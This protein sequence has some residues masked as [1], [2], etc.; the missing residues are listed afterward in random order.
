MTG[1]EEGDAEHRGADLDLTCRHRTTA[2]SGIEWFEDGRSGEIPTQTNGYG[3][4]H[5]ELRIKFP[6]GAYVTTGAGRVV[7]KASMWIGHDRGRTGGAS[8]RGAGRAVPCL[9]L[10][11]DGRGLEREGVQA[12]SDRTAVESSS[13]ALRR[14]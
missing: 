2:D 8:R 13:P 9:I 11:P 7:V 10:P 4:H 12:M 3:G 5:Y 6:D 14:R 1:A